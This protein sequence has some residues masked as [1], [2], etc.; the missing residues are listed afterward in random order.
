LTEEKAF[1]SLSLVFGS[2][3]RVF[4]IDLIDKLLEEVSV[5]VT[6]KLLRKLKQTNKKLS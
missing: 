2:L 3:V 6:A 4:E 1:H 5:E